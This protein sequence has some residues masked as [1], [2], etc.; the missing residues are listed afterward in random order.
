VGVFVSHLGG[1]VCFFEAGSHSVAQVDLEHS[2]YI[3]KAALT[4]TVLPPQPP[5]VLR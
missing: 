5:D 4:L 2:Q 3:A 1:F